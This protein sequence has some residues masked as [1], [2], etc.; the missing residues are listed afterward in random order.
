MGTAAVVVG[1]VGVYIV[2]AETAAGIAAAVGAAFDVVVVVAGQLWL[3]VA[4]QQLLG[5]FHLL[6]EP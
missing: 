2:A 6:L 3:D 5:Q 1:T 4:C